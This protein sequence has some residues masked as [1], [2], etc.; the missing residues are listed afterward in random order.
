MSEQNHDPIPA[1]QA[2]PRK[3]IAIVPDPGYQPLFESSAKIQPRSINGRFS[4]WR[5]AM[6]WLTQLF[7]YGI[8][9]LQMHGR[10]ALLFDLEQRRFYIFGWLLYPQDFIYLAVLLIISALALFLFTAVAGRL[11]CGFSCPQSVYTEIFLWIERRTEGERSARLRLDSGGWSGEKL[12]KRGAKHGLWLLVALWTGVTF[13]GFFVPIR[14]LL[15]ELLSLSGPWQIFWVLFYGLATYGNAGFLREQVCKHMCPYARFQSAMFDRDTLVVTYDAAR[16]EA[17]GAR[18]KN[19]DRK[20]QGLGDCIDC[21]LCVQVCPVGIDIRN[22]LQYECI[23]CGLC[24]D[25]CNSVMDRMQYPRGLIRLST[26]NGLLQGWGQNELIRRLFRP[27]IIVYG[28]AL[29]AISI[30]MVASLSLRT[31]LKVD[32]VR[33]R[34]TLSRIVAGG[35]LENI[36]RVQI[37]NATE[38]DQRYLLKASGLAGIQVAS[39]AEVEVAAAQDRWVVVRLQAPYGIAEPGSHPVF[40]TATAVGDDRLSTQAKTTFLVPR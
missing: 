35:Q 6:V 20:T 21:G 22:G 26:E 7:F 40:L 24:I 17:R 37:G 33:D 3:T 5:W 31:P 32:V 16:G 8:P 10:Q 15:P 14:A 25:A 19:V 12:L 34:G 39:E 27:R 9:W 23:G 28:S 2:K 4:N 18:P 29:L 38:R 1:R 30:A 36:Y 11:W 13:V